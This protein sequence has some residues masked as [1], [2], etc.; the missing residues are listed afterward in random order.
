MKYQPHALSSMGKSTPHETEFAFE[1]SEREFIQNV[2][3]KV[4]IEES[5]AKVLVA[6]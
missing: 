5:C 6:T 1:I 3:Q 2:A 4:Y